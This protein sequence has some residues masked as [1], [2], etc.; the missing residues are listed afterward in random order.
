MSDLG[1]DANE[2]ERRVR[3]ALEGGAAYEAYERWIV[4]QDGNPDPEVLPG[5]PLVREVPAQ[6]AGYVADLDALTIG[7]ATVQLGAGRARKQDAIDHSTGIVCARK[8]GDAVAVGEP[9]ASVHART[10]VEAE[11]ASSPSRR[12]TRS[13][14]SRPIRRRLCSSF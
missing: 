5:A 10:E 8:R 7:S 4:A 13:L 1:M 6:R 12:H 9:L 14:R 11:Q 2:A 3:G